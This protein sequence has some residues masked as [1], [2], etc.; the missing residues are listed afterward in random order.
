MKAILSKLWSFVAALNRSKVVNGIGAFFALVV[1]VLIVVLQNLPPTWKVTL[2]IA[3]AVGVLS[4]AQYIWQK[5]VPLLDG[6]SVIQVKP[7]TEPGVKSLS[8]VAADPTPFE[9]PTPGEVRV[10]PVPSQQPDAAPVD[11]PATEKPTPI[12][13]TPIKGRKG[14]SVVSL[15]IVAAILGLALVTLLLLA[16]GKANAA[17][18]VPSTGLGCVDKGNTYC[19]L[20]ATAVGDQLNLKD[21]SV[22]NGVVLLG[23]VL[24]HEFGT[25]PLGLG[26]YVGLGAST[27]NDSSYQG[28]VGVS[29][30]NWGLLCGGAQRARFSDG[31]TAW[32]GMLTFAG[33]LTY[34]GSPSALKAAAKAVQP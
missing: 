24:Q 27:K 33:Q 34:G 1:P 22:A 18:V 7:A 6:S 31:A 26:L 12:E 14:F 13:G 5:V 21:G 11:L 15:L 8:H 20:P 3:S 32:Q 9:T 30:T 29:I 17:E 28:C 4:R 10:P 16:P 23:L 2:L 19:V 25:L